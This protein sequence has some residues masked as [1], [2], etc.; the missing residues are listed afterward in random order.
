MHIVLFILNIFLPG[1]PYSSF[2]SLGVGTM[3]NSGCRKCKWVVFF[4]GLIQ[5]FCTAFFIG[6]CLSIY[7]GWLIYK[8]SRHLE[9][10]SSSDSDDAKKKKKQKNPHQV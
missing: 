9:S 4:M 10:S 7:W 5:F 6:W 8:K 2:H 1:L 3:L